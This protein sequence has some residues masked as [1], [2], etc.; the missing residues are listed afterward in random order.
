ARRERFERAEPVGHDR[1]AGGLTEAREAPG[2]STESLDERGAVTGL[3][4]V[5][6]V[7]GDDHEL[8]HASPMLGRS[9]RPQPI[10]R[11]A[12]LAGPRAVRASEGGEAKTDR[13]ANA[14]D[15]R[16]DDVLDRAAMDT[17][18]DVDAASSALDLGVCRARYRE[19]ALA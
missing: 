15:G 13:K 10:D 7:V 9:D 16:A 17:R 19:H 11:A 6:S 8:R 18:G 14:L 12:Q 1:D 2:R 5:S 4:R 3:G